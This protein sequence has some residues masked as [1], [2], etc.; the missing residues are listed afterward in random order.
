MKRYFF[1]NNCWLVFIDD[2]NENQKK[3]NEEYRFDFEVLT[4]GC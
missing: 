4:V 2:Y 3:S 1:I